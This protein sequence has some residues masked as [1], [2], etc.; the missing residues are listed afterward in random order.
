MIV[1]LVIQTYSGIVAFAQHYYGYL[2]AKGS[3]KRVDLSHKLTAHQSANLNRA[4]GPGANWKPGQTT[5]RFETEDEVRATAI[6]SYKE[7]F[8]GA[9]AL[10]E[11]SPTYSG[12]HEILDGPPTFV[13]AGADLF[14]EAEEIEWW[15]HRENDDLMG[16]ICD[17]WDALVKKYQGDALPEEEPEP[18]LPPMKP[19]LEPFPEPKPPKKRPTI[20][21]WYEQNPHEEIEIRVRCRTTFNEETGKG[22]INFF[23]SSCDVSDGDGNR[24]GSIKGDTT[25]SV[26]LFKDGDRRNWRIGADDLWYAFVKALEEHD[27]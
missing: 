5:G 6:R 20:S 7:H 25:A 11:G 18:E 16:E 14:A 13:Q 27:K 3:S 4:D 23:Y 17:E 9:V 26:W 1:H 21:E 24:L 19:K 12:P 15:D 22:W 2:T 8:P 10:V